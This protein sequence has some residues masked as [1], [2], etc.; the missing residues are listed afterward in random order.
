MKLTGQKKKIIEMLRMGP[1]ANYAFPMV[2]ILK[3][4]SRMSEL[5]KMGYVIEAVKQERS[6]TWIY[7]LIEDPD[8]TCMCDGPLF[9]EIH[10][11]EGID[12]EA[13][14]A[15]DLIDEVKHRGARW[16]DRDHWMWE[17]EGEG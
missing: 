5:N 3:Y 17:G 11:E 4:T 14:K 9:C 6:S 13:M 16:C 2:N 1:H 12:R 15:D 8:C 10:R 7:H